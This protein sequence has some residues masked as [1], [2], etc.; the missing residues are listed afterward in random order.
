M[1]KPCI[2]S[3]RKMARTLKDARDRR[4]AVFLGAGAAKPF[5]YPL[6]SALLDQI[7]ENFDDPHFVKSGRKTLENYLFRLLPGESRKRKNLPP[8]T[9]L[10][11]LLDYSLT[12]GQSM[13]P[14]ESADETRKA[15]QLLERAILEVINDKEK[16]NPRSD[17]ALDHFADVLRYWRTLS[18]EPLDVMT[19][20]W[21]MSSDEVVGR[22][23]EVDAV[24]ELN[25][26]NE[27]MAAQI[28]FGFGWACRM[29]GGVRKLFS[30]PVT[31]RARLL[32]LH[33]STNWLK[34]PLCDAVYINPRGPNW[35]EAYGPASPKNTC[36]CSK[37]RLE[38]QIVSPSFLREMRE[39]NLLAVWKLALDALRSADDWLIVGYSFPDEDLAVR[40]LFT[41]AYASHGTLTARGRPPT[42][43]V[44]QMGRDAFNRYDAFF[45]SSVLSYCEDGLQA[46]LNAWNPRPARVGRKLGR[47]RRS[48][49]GKSRTTRAR[50]L[51]RR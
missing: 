4:L 22:A 19:T 15:R 47:R 51:R 23:A 42:V 32:K 41:R 33:G 26:N 48:S 50:P 40:A 34:C 36:H 11:S 46:F 5:G 21:D 37:T 12:S 39:P 16:F 7:V 45:D 25:W 29:R 27:D 35:H 38:A 3:A 28:D 44:V 6:S 30:R 1:G 43:N 2:V 31:P 20:N 8:V 13:L 9:S 18:T 10:L 14:R 49:R 24:S 17:R